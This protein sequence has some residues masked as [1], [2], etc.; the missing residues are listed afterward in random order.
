MCKCL[1]RN[2][3]NFIVKKNNKKHTNREIMVKS[4]ENI[5]DEKVREICEKLS[6]SGKSRINMK[7]F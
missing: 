6:K 2:N 3:N 7:Y 5:F 1:N 4:R